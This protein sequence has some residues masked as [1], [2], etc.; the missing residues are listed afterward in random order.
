MFGIK[1]AALSVIAVTAIAGC[2]STSTPG[3]GADLKASLTSLYKD[4]PISTTKDVSAHNTPAHTWLL[5][6]DTHAVFIHWDNDDVSKAKSPLFMGEGVKANF[7]FGDGGI[8]RAQYDDGF[9]HFHLTSAANWDAGHNNGGKYDAAASGW[10]LRHI[11]AQDTT[12]QMMG[13]TMTIKQG[14]V[15]PLMPADDSKVPDC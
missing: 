8:S 6:D 3:G 9:V 5:T 1:L 11:G 2:V 4:T 14:E 7:C 12:M 15:F 10:W 13:E